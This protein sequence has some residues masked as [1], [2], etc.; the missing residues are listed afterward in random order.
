MAQDR[1]TPNVSTWS[2][3]V[4]ADKFR[5]GDLDLY[6]WKEHPE[7]LRR[8]GFERIPAKEIDTGDAG[9]VAVLAT[10]M[11]APF[12]ALS[13]FI[14]GYNE[15]TQTSVEG[16]PTGLAVYVAIGLH[17]VGVIGVVLV[18]WRW[19]RSGRRWSLGESA[20]LGLGTVFAA[21]TLVTLTAETG[22]ALFPVPLTA[23]PMWVFI[24]PAVLV[25]AAI[26]GLSRERRRPPH[27]YFRQVGDADLT[28][29]VGLMAQVDQ[30]KLDTMLGKR[31]RAITRLRDRGLVEEAT[32]A[33][34]RELPTGLSVTRSD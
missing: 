14:G 4:P 15:N 17:L 21:L 7:V 31:S 20:C 22:I 3:T 30:G 6:T 29:A 25:L 2:R 19:W 26:L 24:V 9:Q 5:V 16:L 10:V 28:E 13:A 34:L 1:Q 32:A 12:I 11:L 18:A 33:G 27:T 8:L 23:L